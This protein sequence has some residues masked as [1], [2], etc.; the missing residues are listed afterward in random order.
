MVVLGPMWSD[1]V[2]WGLICCHGSLCCT[3]GS[4]MSCRVQVRSDLGKLH[5]AKKIGIFV[6]MRFYASK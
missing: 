3:M 2:H 1:F 4:D 5:V 6:K